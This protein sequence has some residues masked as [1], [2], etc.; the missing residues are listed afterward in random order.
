MLIHD[1]PANEKFYEIGNEGLEED[2]HP[3]V[4]EMLDTEIERSSPVEAEPRLLRTNADETTDVV[5]KEPQ[6][7]EKM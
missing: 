6:D 3:D 1:I 4:D 5:E 7:D 2:G